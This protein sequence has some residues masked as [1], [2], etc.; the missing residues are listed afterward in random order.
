[1]PPNTRFVVLLWYAHMLRLWSQNQH[2][3]A[4]QFEVLSQHAL[5]WNSGSDR[6]LPG[7]LVSWQLCC[8]LT[9]PCSALCIHVSL[10]SIVHMNQVAHAVWPGS[11]R[12]AAVAALGKERAKT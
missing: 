6:I 7:C 2:M 4:V 11:T 9:C 12:V 3:F 5:L 1:V 10:L 8:T